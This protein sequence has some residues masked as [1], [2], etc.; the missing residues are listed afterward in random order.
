MRVLVC[1]PI[2]NVVFTRTTEIIIVKKY[3]KN[4]ESYS[5]F[6]HS[7]FNYSQKT[8][9]ISLR[10]VNLQIRGRNLKRL[11][12]ITGRGW[13]LRLFVSYSAQAKELH[14]SLVGICHSILLS[15]II[16]SR[17]S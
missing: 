4:W 10:L 14:D 15:T 2:Q 6:L 16:L 3:K 5:I 7:D 11:T 13:G 8:I 12:F 1:Y 17:L 9:Y